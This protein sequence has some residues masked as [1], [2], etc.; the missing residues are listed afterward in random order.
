MRTV[1]ELPSG[2]NHLYPKDRRA[3]YNPAAVRG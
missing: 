1:N 3:C 2:H